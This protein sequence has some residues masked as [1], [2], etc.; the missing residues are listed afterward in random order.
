M[1]ELFNAI[2]ILIDAKVCL[3]I[4][5][6]RRDVNQ[7]D[8]RFNNFTKERNRIKSCESYLKEALQNL[9]RK[10]LVKEL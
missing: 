1:E 10:H 4:E 9:H 3:E 7:N 2:N 5:K 8:Y 6:L